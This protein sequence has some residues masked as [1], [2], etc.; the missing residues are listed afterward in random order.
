MP[1][2]DGSGGSPDHAGPPADVV[3]ELPN[4]AAVDEVLAGKEPPY[5][6]RF[7]QGDEV[8]EEEFVAV[9][10]DRGAQIVEL[11]YDD[12]RHVTVNAPDELEA[13]R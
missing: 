2:A 7:R 13:I 5:G 3:D 9:R 1:G 4:V 6:V 10:T 11:H 12:G 8:V